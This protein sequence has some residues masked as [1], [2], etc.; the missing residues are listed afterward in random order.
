MDAFSVGRQPARATVVRLALADL[1]HEWVLTLC[2]VLALAAVISPL[3]ILMGLKHGTVET[4]RCSLLEDPTYRELR[5]AETHTYDPNWFSAWRTRPEVAF[6]IPTILPASSIIGAARPDTL[7]TQFLDLIPT[8]PGDPLLLGNG[9]LIPGTDE[10]V[11]TQAA[12]EWLGVQ[13]GDHLELRATRSRAGQSEQG[14]TRAIVRSVLSTR[15]SSLARVYAPLD[16]VLDVESYKEGM[17][18][19]G[20]GWTGG[21]PTPYASYDGLFVL[22]PEALTPVQQAALAINTGLTRSTELATAVFRA[23]TGLIVP[24]TSQLYELGVSSGSVQMSSVRAVKDKLRGTG[25]IVIPYV[26]ADVL[27]V[28]AGE[29]TGEHPR[30]IGLSLSLED[31]Q[32]LGLVDLP[33]GSLRAD[34]EDAVRLQQIL[35]PPGSITRGVDLE[36][37]F[38]SGDAA[39]RFPLTV[40]GIGPQGVLLVPAELL[41]ILRTGVDRPVIY[42]SSSGRFLLGRTGFQGFRMYART[43]DDVA[44]LEKALRDEGIEVVSQAQAVERIR[45]LDRGLTRVFLLVAVVGITGGV[46]ALIASLYAAVQRKRRELGVMRLLGLARHAVFRF[47]IYQGT[48]VAGFSILLALVVYFASA[49]V[50]NQIFAADLAVASQSCQTEQHICALPALTLVFAFQGTLVIALLSSLVAAW[51]TTRIDPAEALREE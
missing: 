5:P 17:A 29:S 28:E 12:A 37:V 36:A 43:I 21:S 20:R 15:A 3:L 51:K 11:L 13:V 48:A 41:G 27:C 38:E 50:I 30:V 2:L 40:A 42:D 47:P 33:W 22:A 7:A 46:A 6:L 4:L 35:V 23:K 9:A 45:I 39:A 18:V 19:P 49:A 34:L 31:S 14:T 16:L 1:R 44:G 24:E 8:G 25:A 26:S 10:V 32:R